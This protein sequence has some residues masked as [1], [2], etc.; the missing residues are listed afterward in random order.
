[1]PKPSAEGDGPEYRAGAMLLFSL[2]KKSS[3]KPPVERFFDIL[4]R[5]TLT[6][7]CRVAHLA[8][9]LPLTRRGAFLEVTDIT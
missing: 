5:S 4:S 1:M 2:A 7:S 6:A 8:E 3:Q 9:G